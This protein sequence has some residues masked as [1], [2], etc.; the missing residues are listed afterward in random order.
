MTQQNAALVE[1]T[2]SASQAMSDQARELLEVIAFFK[3]GET[4]T[5]AADRRTGDSKV[6]VLIEWSG[7]LSVGDP[8]LDRQHQKLIGIINSFHEAMASRKSQT[9]IGDLLD[10]LNT[11]A[12]EHFRYEE[13]RMRAGGYPQLAEHRETHAAMLGTVKEMQGRFKQGAL[14]Q[15]EFMKLLKNWLTQHIQKSDKQYTPYL[16]TSGTH[17]THSKSPSPA[18]VKSAPVTVRPSLRPVPVEK[19]PALSTTAASEWEEF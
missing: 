6:K 3:L 9:V 7:A 18:A 15:L 8:E 5:I 16:R 2:A 4:P 1:E 10:K 11:Y 17:A 19:R 12:L 14:S 13:E